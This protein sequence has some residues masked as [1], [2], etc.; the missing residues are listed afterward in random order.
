MRLFVASAPAYAQHAKE[1]GQAWRKHLEPGEVEEIEQVVDRIVHA[2]GYSTDVIRP[3]R[4]SSRKGR[5]R[6]SPSAPIEVT[7]DTPG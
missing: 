6:A 2:R 1:I 7:P 3:S 5:L 4:T